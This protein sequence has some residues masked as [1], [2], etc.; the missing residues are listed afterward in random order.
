MYG[1]KRKIRC[2]NKISSPLKDH[3]H[4][5][6][7]FFAYLQ[8]LEILVFFSG[9]PLIYLLINSLGRLQGIGVNFRKRILSVL[10]YTYALI[11]TLFLGFEVKNISP[12]FTIAHILERIQ[13]P[14]LFGWGI[15]S[16][17]FWIRIVNR[18]SWLS[19]IHSLVFLFFILKDILVNETTS[20]EDHGFLKNNMR[21]YTI[22]LL[23]NL[24]ALVVIYFL[25]FLIK[26]K[27]GK[28]SA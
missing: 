23:L 27:R 15:L 9:Y 24:A 12:D 28:V 14:F 21:V 7:S 13:H 26:A 22:S 11:G 8:Q 3:T 20:V 6:N 16:L 19:L 1:T 2:P 10:P 4:M 17:I 18:V 25:S 5:D